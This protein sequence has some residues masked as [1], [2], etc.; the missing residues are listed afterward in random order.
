M[1]ARKLP[2]VENADGGRDVALTPQHSGGVLA[3]AG[4]DRHGRIGA[5]VSFTGTQRLDANPY[6]SRSEDYVLT[7]LFAERQF[8]R[9]RVFVNAD[10]VS[11]VRQTN[12]D[13]LVRPARDVDGRWTVDA[14]APLR[15]R[16]INAGI[17]ASF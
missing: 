6:R 14:W 2:L 13:P 9:W 1:H 10:N 8:G 15:G 4:S 3:T 11:D 5:R 16:A 17:R 7:G 12:W